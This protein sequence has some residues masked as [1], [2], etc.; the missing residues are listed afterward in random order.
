MHENVVKPGSKLSNLGFYRFLVWELLLCGMCDLPRCF[1]DAGELIRT[2]VRRKLDQ[3]TP[4]SS[5]DPDVNTGNTPDTR[6]SSVLGT[7]PLRDPLN[8][9]L[10]LFIVKNDERF[11]GELIQSP[12]QKPPRTTHR[13][14][15]KIGTRQPA[16][17]PF[18]KQMFLTKKADLG[19]LSWSWGEVLPD[20]VL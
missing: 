2:G 1:Q 16:V 19:S 4:Y 8:F 13:K 9:S 7:I 12:F 15:L 17:Y 3:S 20:A 11:I 6:Q 18:Q 14:S 5:G 10:R